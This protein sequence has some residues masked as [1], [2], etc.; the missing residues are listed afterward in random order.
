M[1]IES[2]IAI[3]EELEGYR[4]PELIQLRTD[5][6]RLAVKYAGIRAG[7]NFLSVEEKS[8][9]SQARTLA[10]NAFIDACNI[11]SR[12]VIRE[13]GSAEWRRQLGQDRKEIGDFA[14]YLACFLGI[15]AR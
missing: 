8:A 15:R 11:L 1:N 9:S 13:G 6:Y 14:C 5:T 10:H 7:W 12:A 2:A 4:D 3:Y